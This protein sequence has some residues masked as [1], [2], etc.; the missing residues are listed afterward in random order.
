MTR[1]ARACATAPARAWA[2]CSGTGVT[3]AAALA[4][5]LASPAINPVVLVATA[6]AFPGRPEMVVARFAA[7]LVVAV[8]AGWLWLR[9][10][11][12]EWLRVPRASAERG[13]RAFVAA[14][15]HDLLHAGGFLVVGGIAAA[16]LNVL[17]PRSWLAAVAEIGWLSVLVLAA[18]VFGIA[19]AWSQGLQID[20]GC[21]GDGGYNPDAASQYPWEIARDVVL[22]ALSL[23]L[24]VAPRTRLALDSVL[25]RGIEAPHEPDPDDPDLHD[26]DP[27]PTRED[28]EA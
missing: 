28:A 19:W 12:A 26:P 24:V 17:V 18:F 16:T 14:M 1:T 11:R 15:R 6:V 7:S 25:F 8:L 13:W 4:F 22:A 21:F 20:C 9:F 10:G 23:F 2:S 27:H 5:L 3:P